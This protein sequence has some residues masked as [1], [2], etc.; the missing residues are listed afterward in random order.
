MYSVAKDIS[1]IFASLTFWYILPT[2]KDGVA[3]YSPSYSSKHSC[4]LRGFLYVPQTYNHP[5]SQGR[6]HRTYF[7]KQMNRTY[8]VETGIS[9]DFTRFGWSN[10]GWPRIEIEMSSEVSTSLTTF[11][12][13]LVVG[14]CQN[15]YSRITLVGTILTLN[16]VFTLNLDSYDLHWTWF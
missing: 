5:Y 14:I 3:T 15:W 9:R 10:L 16:M 8:C 13:L 2:K 11:W 12:P 4:V 1:F 6:H 7:S